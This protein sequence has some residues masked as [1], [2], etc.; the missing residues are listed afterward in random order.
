MSP[1]I[2]IVSS[3]EEIDNILPADILH[4][5]FRV[6]AKDVMH[7]INV[8]Q[9]VKAIQFSPGHMST[10][11]ESTKEFLKFNNI[12]LLEGN[13]LGNDFERYFEDDDRI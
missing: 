11:S 3:R 5:S 13:V 8:H 2:R 6:S 7:L 12:D 1:K 9:D 4:F 10:I